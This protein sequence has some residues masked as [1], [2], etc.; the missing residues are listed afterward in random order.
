[1]RNKVMIITGTSR[2]IGNYLARHYL[3]KG[4]LVAGCSRKNAGFKH[5][6]YIHYQLDISIEK[7]VCSMVKDIKNKFKNID[8]LINNAGKFSVNHLALTPV[9]TV[10]EIFSIN[11]LGTFL[12]SREVGKI[13]VN[14]KK[15]RIVNI[16]SVAVPMAIEGESVYAA[17]KAAVEEFTKVI[18]KELSAYNITV[19]CLGVAPLMTDS[20]KSLPKNK[21]NKIRDS[22]NI[23][24]LT[25][26]EDVSN[27]IDFFI[28]EESE[29][30]TGQVIYLGGVG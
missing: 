19:N 11:F 7:D 24:R 27:V 3:E 2:G 5:K 21:I 4:F 15:G 10:K 1:M 22:L 30:V 18:A 12:F 28:K 6:N 9:D 26:Y 23:K 20:L 29:Y 14:Q 17:S 16:S 25:R 8:I 13:M